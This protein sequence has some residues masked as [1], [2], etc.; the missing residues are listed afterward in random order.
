L[1]AADLLQDRAELII[2]KKLS[3]PKGL[4]RKLIVDVNRGLAPVGLT[5]AGDLVCSFGHGGQLF[6]R[7]ASGRKVHSAFHERQR[8]SGDRGNGF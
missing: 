2:E 8:N 6:E 5:P 3:V 1:G 7:R 4:S